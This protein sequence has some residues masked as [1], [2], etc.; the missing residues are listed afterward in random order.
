[1]APQRPA[2]P[3]RVSDD[4]D[5][6]LIERYRPWLGPPGR[7]D[8]PD[9]LGLSLDAEGLAITQGKRLSRRPSFTT[10]PSGWRL[11]HA[12]VKREAL[13]R[14]AGLKRGHRPA[15]IDATAGL[16][17]DGLVLARLGCPVTLVER[18]TTVAALLDDA[19]RR[20]AAENWLVE[21]IARTTLVVADGASYLAALPAAEYPN[22][23]YLDPMFA[24]TRRRG[25]AGKGAQLLAEIAGEPGD[26]DALLQPALAAAT[27]R[28]VVKRHRHAAPLAE[29]E[30]S[31][32]I[33][34]KSTR[35][36]V[37]ISY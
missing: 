14:A 25:A 1:M 22:V 35:F 6:A 31:F 21:A 29:T 20:A 24:P 19:L 15:I 34:G 4:A 10:G 30:P 3:F 11:A 13:A 9:E 36:D 8:M 37:H 33:D 7:G 28:V 17:G 18:N 5:P 23:V 16:G 2:L 26:G 27:E 12:A 32:D